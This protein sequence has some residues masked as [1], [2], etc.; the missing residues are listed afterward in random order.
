M[1]LL[2]TGATT[3]QMRFS[4]RGSTGSGASGYVT[5]TGFAIPGDGLWHH[6]VFSLAAGSLTPVFGP[7]PLATF[8][9]NVAE[10]RVFHAPSAN[11]T[12]GVDFAGSFSVD[13]I[14]ALAVVPEPGS[15]L[16]LALAAAGALLRRR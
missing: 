14:R 7:P 13:N 15:T 6:V 16:L 5:T 8:L 4:L 12:Q 3:L 9:G 10:A 2:N 11:T 1:D